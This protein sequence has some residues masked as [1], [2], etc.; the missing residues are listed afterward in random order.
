MVNPGFCGDCIVEV[1]VSSVNHISSINITDPGTSVFDEGDVMK[2]SNY[3]LFVAGGSKHD[4][5]KGY[6][7]VKLDKAYIM[8]HK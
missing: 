1:S 3:E 2:L 5:I 4:A 7:E 6:I 8:A